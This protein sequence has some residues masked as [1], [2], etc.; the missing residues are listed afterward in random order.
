MYASECSVRAC[1][2]V[3]VCAVKNCPGN[4]NVSVSMPP[5]LLLFP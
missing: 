5:L 3:C 4:H 2:C 1:V